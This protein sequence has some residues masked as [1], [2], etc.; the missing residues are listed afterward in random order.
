[1]G[2]HIITNTTTNKG[3]GHIYLMFS[4]NVQDGLDKTVIWNSAVCQEMFRGEVRI[5]PCFR[6]PVRLQVLWLSESAPRRRPY[7]PERSRNTVAASLFQSAYCTQTLSNKASCLTYHWCVCPK[8]EIIVKEQNKFLLPYLV[9]IYFIPV[10]LAIM[11]F[12]KT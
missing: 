6:C 1:M 5:C 7:K 8:F 10:F 9:L 12:R 11:R 2:E 4:C 3:L